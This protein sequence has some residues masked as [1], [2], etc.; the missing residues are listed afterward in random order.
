MDVKVVGGA[1]FKRERQAYLDMVIEKARQAA[2]PVRA[3]IRQVGVDL[4]KIRLP[5]GRILR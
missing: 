5:H 3:Y 1:E 2:G 4:P